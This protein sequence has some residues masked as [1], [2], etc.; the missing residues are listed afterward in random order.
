MNKQEFQNI[1]KDKFLFLDG[2]TG[3]NLQKRGMPSGV[4]PELWITENKEVLIGLQKEYVEAGSNVVYAPTFSANRIKL[5]GYG[6]AD[7]TEELNKT[8]VAISREA[9][10]DKAYV[11]GDLTMT[12]ELLEP[13]GTLSFEELIDIYKEQIGCL[14][15][16]GVDLLIVE[17]MMSLQECRA[18]LIAAKETAPDLPIMV[19]MTF[20]ESGKT[21]YGT[22]AVT[23]AVV[24]ES[25]GADA[26]GVNCSTGPEKMAEVV[27]KI[28]AVTKIP[29][30]AKPNA[31]LP[32]LDENGQTVYEMGAEEFGEKMQLLADAGALILGGCCGTTPDH[33][34]AL[35]KTVKMPDVKPSR[36]AAGMHYLT[37]ERKTVSF[38][39]NDPLVVIGERINP[40]GK[41]D[42]QEEFMEGEFYTLEDMAS[43]QEEMGA[44]LLDINCGMPGI[45][46]KETMLLAMDA[47]A[48]V[49]KLPL[50]LDSSDADVLE[51]ALR[52]YPGRALV[53]SVTLE[54]G[55]T[56]RLLMAVKKYG[57]MFIVMPYTEAGVPLDFEEKKEIIENILKKAYDLGF[58]KDDIVI[59]ALV[60]S[61]AVN[62]EAAKEALEVIRYCRENQIASVCGISNISYGMPNRSQLNAAFMTLAAGSGLHMAFMNPSQKAVSD[63]VITADLFAAKEEAVSR[64]FEKIRS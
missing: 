3:S 30:I 57:A 2:A 43:E 37:S 50:V 5:D 23:A 52:R 31:G 19:T 25:L 6:L 15:Q 22:D 7:R 58:S 44:Q 51:A 21:L 62:P 4:C 59:D 41:E 12:G 60:T 54:E 45:D 34:R 10:G 35:T 29:V 64:Y 48:G 63:A 27:K 24:L 39:L 17:T 28:V 9:A 40:T 16:A 53:N 49:T 13:I 11:A 46:E 38:G 47:A 14:E 55:K 20:E 33:I 32:S 56:D 36:K 61:L 1:L 26:I 42:L 18:A 8:L